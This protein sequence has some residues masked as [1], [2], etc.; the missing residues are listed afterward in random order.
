MNS[1]L[2]VKKSV[3]TIE[4][5]LFFL[6]LL[7][8]CLQN[9][10]II[11]FESGFSFKVSHVI[12]IMFLPILI[13][14]E[15][16][17]LP[18]MCLTSFFCFIMIIT[19]FASLKYGFNS[20]IFN[21]IAGFYSL[22]LFMT[23]GGKIEYYQWLK[24]IKSV[25]W[26]MMFAIIINLLIH[27]DIILAFIKNPYNHPI[28]DTI[29]GGGVNLEA[30]W[31]TMLGFSFY[32]DKKGYIYWLLCL[33]ISA[34]YVSR[35]GL[36]ACVMLLLFLV[37]HNKNINMAQMLK[38]LP[39]IVIV[40]CIGLLILNKIGMLDYALERMLN[41]GDSLTDGGTRGRFS[42]W[43][44]VFVAAKNNPLGYGVGNGTNAI[45][46]VSNMDF[47]EN[48]LHNFIFQMLLDV[49]VFGLIFYILIIAVFSFKNIR[50]LFKDPIITFL[51]TYIG[52]SLVQ[53]RGGESIMFYML[54]IYL[55][56]GNIYNLTGNKL[57][58]N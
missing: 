36:V 4:Y 10:S 8:N 9:A 38:K 23:L 5:L 50:F 17:R 22:I 46:I 2:R 54:G 47:S 7:F 21:Y 20:L 14:Q 56:K 39:L 42:M 31:I 27:F 45:E 25:A 57:S 24:L 3:L 34:V 53:F 52:L 35:A 18:N 13:R 32:K 11:T 33:A 30:T 26:I 1:I 48:N 43:Q 28:V 12:I 19:I 6:L 40:G 51:F 29:F 44:Y 16:I 41:I 55:I 15:K 37:F 58:I 49:G